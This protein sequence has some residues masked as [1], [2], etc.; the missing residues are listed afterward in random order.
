MYTIFIDDKPIN[1]L[2]SS[3]RTVSNPKLV[4]EIGKAGSLEF[5][6]PSVNPISSEFVPLKT[7]V[8]VE[9]DGEELFDGRVL[10]KSKDFWN[11]RK[12]TCEGNLAYLVDSVQKGEK[13]EG[14]THDLFKQIINQRIYLIFFY[15]L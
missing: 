8:R 15:P 10:T 1:D 14:K 4:L 12:I 3:S 9:V 5:S 7:K 13:Y 6:I 2:F 11:T